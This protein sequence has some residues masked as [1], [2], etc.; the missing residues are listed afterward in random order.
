[1]FLVFFKVVFHTY[2]NQAIQSKNTT[3]KI[4]VIFSSPFTLLDFK[5]CKTQRSNA[6]MVKII[7]IKEGL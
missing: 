3:A 7:E 4:Q 5:I 6:I 1:M 2:I